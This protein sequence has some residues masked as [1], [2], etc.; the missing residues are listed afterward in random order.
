MYYNN[1]T[2]DGGLQG[3][4]FTEYD[5]LYFTVSVKNGTDVTV[6]PIT[7][8]KLNVE[9]GTQTDSYSG[10]SSTWL[11]DGDFW[12][13]TSGTGTVF[14]FGSGVAP[15]VQITLVNSQTTIPGFN[16]TCSGSS[17]GGYPRGI[18]QVGL[19][20]VL[21]DSAQEMTDFNFDTKIFPQN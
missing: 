8:F 3:L 5:T 9:P 10:C 19:S 13:V 12:N 16:S 7:N 17:I 4:A 18:T 1:K 20:F 6:G 21:A 11:K 15:A 14:A 2:V